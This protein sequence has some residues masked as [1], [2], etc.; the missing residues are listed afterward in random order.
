MAETNARRTG[1]LLRKL[2]EILIANPDGIRARDALSQLVSKVQ[3]TPY[4]AGYYQRGAR[5]FE[6]IVR[7]ATVDVVKA[8][9]M[10]KTKG[11]WMITE[12]GR[13]AYKRLP[14]PEMFYREG[15]RLYRAWKAS[16]PSKVEEDD[17]AAV[18]DV[19]AEGRVG[20][21]EVTRTFEEAEEEAWQDVE[22]FLLQMNP[23]DLQE[24]VAGLLRAM[25]YHAAWVAPPGKDGGV[26]ILAFSDPLGTKPPRIKVQVKRQQ[27]TV[28]VDGLRSFLALLGDEDVGIF[29]N[30]G[31]FTRDA[32]EEARLQETRKITLLD[33]E[34]LFD[35]WVEYYSKLDDVTRRRMPLRPIYFLAPSD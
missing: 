13:D 27:Q 5:R 6:K 24:L 15:S 16:Q 31:G 7:F 25:G 35:L 34:R 1:E 14:D 10:L 26:D 3:L 32:Q 30:I 4:E 28:S 19:E 33:V 21:R 20:E 2:F 9:W 17:Q 18:E 29:L 23:Y 22:R 12:D 11:T 8:G